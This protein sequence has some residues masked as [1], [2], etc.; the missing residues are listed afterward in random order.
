[1][2][3]LLGSC[4][5]SIKHRI[6]QNYFVNLYSCSLRIGLTF[7]MSKLLVIQ[8]LTKVSSIHASCVSLLSSLNIKLNDD[9]YLRKEGVYFMIFPSTEN[10]NHRD[11]NDS[12]HPKDDI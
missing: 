2:Y 11:V 12:H 10:C 9:I 5:T 1:M 6:L 7:P 4:T 3:T 8:W